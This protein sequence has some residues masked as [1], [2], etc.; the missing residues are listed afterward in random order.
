MTRTAALPT[1]EEFVAECRKDATER[2]L[3]ERRGDHAMRAGA[4]GATS[5][6]RWIRNQFGGIAK[7]LVRSDTTFVAAVN[8]PAAGVGLAFALACDG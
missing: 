4:Q 5:P 3:V 7:L 2:V 1:Y 6:W 8:G